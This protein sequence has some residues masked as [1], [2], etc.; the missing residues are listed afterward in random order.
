[1]SQNY[2]EQSGDQQVQVPSQVQA[3]GQSQTQTHSQNQI[4]TINHPNSQQNQWNNHTSQGHNQSSHGNSSGQREVE[5]LDRRHPRGRFSW[6]RR[7]MQGQNRQQIPEM[8]DNSTIAYNRGYYKT[9]QRNGT[10]KSKRRTK[11]PEHEGSSKTRATSSDGEQA[12]TSRQSQGYSNEEDNNSHT[13]TEFD[14]DDIRSGSYN[15]DQA[16]EHSDNILTTPL[17][18]IVSSPSTKS[19]SVL[20]GDNNQDTQSYNASTA[21]TSIAPSSH[22][23]PTINRDGLPPPGG[24]RDSESIVTLASSS[25]RIRR[26]SLETNSSTTGIPPASIMERIFTQPTANNSAYANSINP[27][28]RGS[29]HDDVNSYRDFDSQSSVPDSN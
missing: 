24:E 9:N 26:R 3:P 13:D 11:K 23:N 22:L 12:N 14:S 21:E 2:S 28:E 18:S 20:S 4:P 27:T 17:K 7:L 15:S 6:V 25:R 16:T 29:T 10:S 8:G 19:P 5:N 1:M